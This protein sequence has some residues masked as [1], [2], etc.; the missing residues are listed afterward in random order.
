MQWLIAQTWG[1][2]L[3][4]A[5][6]GGLIGWAMRARR[7]EEASQVAADS[8]LQ[9]RIKQLETQLD[10]ERKTSTD[11]SSRLQTTTNVKEVVEIIP[12]SD[13]EQSLSW[14][15]R[16]LETRNRFLE[17]KVGDLE[18]AE[19]KRA[20][21]ATDDRATRLEWRNRYLEGRVKYLEEELVTSGAL[22]T[23]EASAAAPLEA[24]RTE[25]EA[26]EKPPVLTG[27]RGGKADDLKEIAGIGPKIEG[28]LNG[29]GVY[30]FD[31]IAAW[32]APQVTWVNAAISFKGRVEREKWIDQA[33]A[34][35]RGEMTDG[36]QKYREGKHT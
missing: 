22:T 18:A 34:L 11:L 36:K 19:I 12:A 2:L 6:F 17:Q 10:L 27:P 29:L 13:E 9:T 26:G 15:A 24:T 5:V 35:A 28:V 20:E 31:Q 3:L 1:Y 33:A 8:G 4:A 14:R 21:V 30:H 7:S 32:T 23:A 25:V 16:Y